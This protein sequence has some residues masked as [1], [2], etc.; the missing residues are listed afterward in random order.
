MQRI[1]PKTVRTKLSLVAALLA[2]GVCGPAAAAGRDP[3]AH[4][5]AAGFAAMLTDLG[6][7]CDTSGAGETS[8][9]FRGR[10]GGM[11]AATMN[12]GGM[13]SVLFAGAAMDSASVAETFAAMAA[14]LQFGEGTLADRFTEPVAISAFCAEA[15]YVGTGEDAGWCDLTVVFSAAGDDVVQNVT[16]ETLESLGAA[17]I[18][19]A[20]LNAA[21]DR[22]ALDPGI[23]VGIRESAS[24]PRMTAIAWL[25]IEGLAQ[26]A[27]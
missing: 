5:D 3:V 26:D 20:S 10:E 19:R 8:C 15:G 27:E 22:A 2:A 7:R 21:V 1:E 6:F 25:P 11:M 9:L 24:T 16:K 17:E 12:P 13:L 4:G 18:D 14:E 23:Y